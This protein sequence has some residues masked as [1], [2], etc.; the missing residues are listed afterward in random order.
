MLMWAG[1][2]A[3]PVAWALQHVIGWGVSEAACDPVG[4]QWGVPFTTWVVVLDLSAALFAIGGL[5]AAITAFRS[6]REAGADSDPPPG[7]IWLLSIMGL[8]LSPIFL[9]MIVLTG[10]GALLLGHCNQG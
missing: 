3:P 2:G 9:A 7:R 4:R 6:V 5:A 10:A 8:V 1:I